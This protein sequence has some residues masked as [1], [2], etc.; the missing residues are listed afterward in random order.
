MVKPGCGIIH[1]LFPKALVSVPQQDIDAGD[2][3][4]FVRDAGM[5]VSRFMAGRMDTDRR[6][7]A[8]IRRWVRQRG[9]A[10]ECLDELSVALSRHL[11]A[12]ARVLR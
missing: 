10:R 4:S 5:L 7:Q 9:P 2:S 8:M 11:D 12:C 1:V 6:V 3:E